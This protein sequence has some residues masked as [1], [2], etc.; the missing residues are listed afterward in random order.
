MIVASVHLRSRPRCFEIQF[1]VQ[2]QIY[3]TKG[4][5]NGLSPVHSPAL[6]KPK[7]TQDLSSMDIL[8]WK[9]FTGTVVPIPQVFLPIA[10]DWTLHNRDQRVEKGAAAAAGEQPT[11]LHSIQDLANRH[12]QQNIET[13]IIFWNIYSFLPEQKYWHVPITNS[14][15]TSNSIGNWTKQPH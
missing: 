12:C 13:E 3:C 11:C 8:L 15:R 1:W 2:P 7:N 9:H 6:V 5:H 10:G 4:S 14:S